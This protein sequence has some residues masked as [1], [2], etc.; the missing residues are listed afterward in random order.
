MPNGNALGVF[1]P[2]FKILNFI[3]AVDKCPKEIPLGA[4]LRELR[5][6]Y[7]KHRL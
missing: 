4:T 2:L 7:E 5:N 1:P 6:K 3:L